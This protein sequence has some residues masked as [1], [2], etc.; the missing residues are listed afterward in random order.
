MGLV[1]YLYYLEKNKQK[2][3]NWDCV[4]LQT[5]CMILIVSH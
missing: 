4:I 2:K 5:L 1:I 3:P